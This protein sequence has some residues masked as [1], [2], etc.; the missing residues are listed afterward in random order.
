MLKEVKGLEYA[1]EV[2]RVLTNNPGEHD[3]KEIH[4]LIKD[5]ER[6]EASQSYVQKVLPRMA[7]ASLVNSSSSGYT[8]N[9]PVEEITIDMLLDLCDMPR[10]NEPIFELCRKLKGAVSLNSVKEIYEFYEDR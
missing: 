6:I 2:L 4:N 5:G 3:S 1:L 7:R 10:H 8:L 9:R